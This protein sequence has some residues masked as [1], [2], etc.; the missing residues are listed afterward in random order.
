MEDQ[1]VKWGIIGCGQV[2]EVKSGPAFQLTKGFQVYAV[3][4][5]NLEKLEDY[6]LRHGVEQ[7]YT[8]AEELI[9]DKKVDAIYIAT[10]PHMHKHFALQV[11]KAGKICCIEKPFTT[12]YQESLEV[13]RLFEE[14]Q[15]PLFVSYYRRSLPRFHRV[16]DWLEKGHIGD[17]RNVSWSL[18]R[19]PKEIDLLG[20]Y[21]WR[22]DDQIAPGGYF[23]DLACH[24]LNLFQYFF[25][26]IDSVSGSSSNQQGLY[27]AKDAITASW[28]HKNGITGTG[29][30]NFGCQE[31][32]DSVTIV[33]NKGKISFSIFQDVPLILE[34]KEIQ[35][36]IH[37][38][39]PVNIQLYHAE[40]IRK[41]LMENSFTHPSTSKSALHTNWVMDRILMKI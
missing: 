36:K 9:H 10:P 30:W 15:I 37:I 19:P 6:A 20:T 40:N 38:E 39:N 14:K 23:N 5:R 35:K 24:G 1:I 22:T 31:F 21:N 29:S 26:N 2:T 18:M 13:H 11:A 34:S 16:K 8:N 12:S 25:G 33:G 41:H 3:M 32:E 17:I 28:I 4:R 7:Y 27:K